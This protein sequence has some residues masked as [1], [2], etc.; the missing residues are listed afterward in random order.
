MEINEYREKTIQIINRYLSKEITA[1]EASDWALKKIISDEF[2]QLPPDIT[3]A[4]HCLF[5]LHDIDVPE[6]SWV[7]GIETF[8]KCKIELE[9]NR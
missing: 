9:N 5:D 1:K 2:E 8:I 3:E 7:P 4:L 6:A